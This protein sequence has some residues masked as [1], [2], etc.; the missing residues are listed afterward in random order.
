[1]NMCGQRTKTKRKKK[2]E[3]RLR[4]RRRVGGLVPRED[5]AASIALGYQG[6]SILVGALHGGRDRPFVLYDRLS[7]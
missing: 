1:M 2:N 3:T 6:L 4:N 7:V 5:E